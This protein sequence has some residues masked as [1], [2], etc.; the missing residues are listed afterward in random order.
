MCKDKLVKVKTYNEL[1][2]GDFVKCNMCDAVML[3]W[4]GADK[5]PECSEEG[6]LSWMNENEPEASVQ[7]LSDKG[8]IIEPSGKTLNMEDYLAK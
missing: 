7:E 1:S 8:Y 6:Y 2:H 5:C 4:C 3:L